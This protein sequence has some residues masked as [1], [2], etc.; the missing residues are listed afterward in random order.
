MK[1]KKGFF[2]IVGCGALAA[3][4][5]SGCAEDES[6]S[7]SRSDVLSFSVDS[8]SLDTTFSNVPTPTASFWVY[9][10]AGKGL[11]CSSVRLENGNQSG[12]RVNVD[13]TYL[14]ETA[15][16]QTQDVEVRKGDSI[17]VFIELTSHTQH[18]DTPR[19]VEDH[20]VFTLESGVQQ[21]MNLY[22]YSWDALMMRNARIS[23]DSL[24]QSAKPVVVY[25][26]I[27]VDSMATLTVGAGTQLF[28]HEDAGMQVYGTL[29]VKGE[30]GKEVV[31]RGDRLDHMFDYLPYDRTPGQWQGIEL[32]SSSYDNEIS[33]ADIHSA[34]SALKVDSGDVS[35]QK[36]LLQNS[37]VHNNQGWGV[38]IDS[39]KVQI[40][41]C[42]LSNALL[43]PLFVHGGDVEVNGCTIA[44]FYPFDGRRSTALGF[45]YPLPQLTVRNS[46]ITGYHDDEVVWTPPSSEGSSS[47]GAGSS[48][49]GSSSEGS[50]AEIPFNFLFDHCVL[51]TEKMQGDDSLKFTNVIYEDVKDTTMYGE[52]H[53]VLFDTDNLKYDFRLRKESAAIGK[54]D[55]ATSLPVDRNGLRR[56][57]TPDA[58]CYESEFENGEE[59]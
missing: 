6:F 56:K 57:E 12:F 28:F 49:G 29:K 55:A 18:Q 46:L 15:G 11:R 51:R 34:Y 43:S 25:G 44:Q 14:G 2:Y 10:R 45:Q 42:Q 59:E 23:R 37:S 9:N 40:H 3:A 52:K 20:L 53:F 30:A 35:R 5:L 17:R 16:Y 54:A 31:M 36:L 58:G 4:M 24:L 50:A 38:L 32:M 41:D 8:V 7:T 39:A 13:G 27:R 47:S 19:K 21:K 33:Y 48:S 22:A 1:R 26:G